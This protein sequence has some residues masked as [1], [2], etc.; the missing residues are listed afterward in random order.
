VFRA[1]HAGVLG[2]AIALAYPLGDVVLVT[3]VFVVV[4]RIR[5]GGARCCCSGPAWSAWP[6]PTPGSPT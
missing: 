3:V 5:V 4:A 1:S 6:W 2:Q